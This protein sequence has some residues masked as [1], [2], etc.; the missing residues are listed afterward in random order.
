MADMLIAEGR[1]EPLIIV[2]VYHTG[3]G[4]VHE[5]TPTKDARIGGGEARAYGRLLVEELK[6]FI[7]AR[8]R[9]EPGRECTGLGGASLGGLVS[10]YLGLRHADV[11]GRLAVMSPSVWWGNRAILRYVA[12][13][14]PKPDTRIWLDMGTAESRSGIADARRLRA[15][16]VK[17]GWREDVDLAYWE[18]QGGT[19]SEAA[20]A[21]RVDEMLQFLYPG[22][23]GEFHW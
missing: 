11:F 12:K 6:P 2:G 20:W 14:V 1:V 17:A 3:H 4:R 9:T 18:R 22:E 19:H 16:L 15:A 21:D 8:Y 7:D 13:A 10:M 5:Y 23:F